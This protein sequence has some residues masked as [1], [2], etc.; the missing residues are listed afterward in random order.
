VRGVAA[1]RAGAHDHAGADA[2]RAVVVHVDARERRAV[3]HLAP[4]GARERAP[5]AGGESRPRPRLDRSVQPHG[6]V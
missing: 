5:C 6:G 4:R 2:E 3:D 1:A